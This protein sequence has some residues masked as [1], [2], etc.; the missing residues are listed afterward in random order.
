MI[1]DDR[2]TLLTVASGDYA[3]RQLLITADEAESPDL[4]VSVREGLLSMY[5]AAMRATTPNWARW[6]SAS[7]WSTWPKPRPCSPRIKKRAS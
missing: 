5:E 2:A 4:L 7:H 1:D 6:P 3:G